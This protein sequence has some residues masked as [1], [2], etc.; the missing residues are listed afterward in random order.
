MFYQLVPG[1]FMHIELSL[2]FSHSVRGLSHRAS[3]DITHDDQ[4]NFRVFCSP[5]RDPEE[6]DREAAAGL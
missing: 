6:G 3:R 5:S 1:Q 2:H 4:G